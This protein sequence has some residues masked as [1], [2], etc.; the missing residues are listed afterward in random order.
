[1][2]QVDVFWA[3]AIGAGCGAAAARAAAV[4]SSGGAAPPAGH[5]G[6][7][8]TAHAAGAGQGLLGDRRF[9]ATVLYLACVFAPSGLWLVWRFTGWETMHAASAPADMPGWLVAGF[10]L[11]NVTQGVLGY[12][13]A[14]WLWRHGRTYLAWAQMP[15]GYL[16]MFFIL[17]YGWDGTGYRR[18]LAP[19]TAA[20]R[21]GAVDPPAFLTSDVAFT[22]YGMGA[23]LV[24]LL[25]WLQAS[26]WSAGERTRGRYACLVLL[27]VLGVGLGTAVALAAALTFLGGA[28]GPVVCAALLVV[29]FHPKG[30]AGRL[31]RLFPLT[32][33]D[34]H[35]P[36]GG[37]ESVK[38]L[39]GAVAMQGP[40]AG[41]NSSH[42]K[43]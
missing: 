43:E 29:V 13:V 11:T 5:D 18:F 26:W 16:A 6:L 30:L 2:I 8:K 7:A 3:Y 41:S 40:T 37:A 9:T 32:M 34:R 38:N 12:A 15:L 21:A 24:P 31:A 25:L 23:V 28:T 35:G 22:L 36:A 42:R 19:S 20:W 4:V 14:G 10:A 39:A 33:A 27:A 17:V 1:M